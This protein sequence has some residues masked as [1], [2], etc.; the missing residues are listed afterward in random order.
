MLFCLIFIFAYSVY[1]FMVE[2]V[3]VSLWVH[4][5]KFVKSALSSH[6]FVGFQDQT[7]GLRLIR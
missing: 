3:C 4:V 2:R 1:R 5:D 6:S 7:R